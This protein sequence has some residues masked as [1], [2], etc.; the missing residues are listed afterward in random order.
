LEVSGMD[1]DGLQE[2][3]KFQIPVRRQKPDGRGDD[4]HVVEID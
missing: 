1:D 4:R 2:I 3:D